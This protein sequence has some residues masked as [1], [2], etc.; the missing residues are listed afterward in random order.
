[1]H[2]AEIPLDLP[3]LIHQYGYWAVLLG[4]LLEGETVLLLAGYAAHRGYLDWTKVTAIAWI[5][6]T[7][8]DQCFFWLGRRHGA[9]LL[10]RGLIRGRL[11]RALALIEAHSLGVIFSMRFLYGLRIALPIA[12]GM[13]RV[14]AGRFASFNLV[15]AALWAVLVAGAGWVFG[16]AI[17]RVVGELHRYEAALMAGLAVAAWLLHRFLTRPRR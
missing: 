3:A 5:G 4:T 1:M 8:G 15:S 14:A 2:L 6:A 11:A 9:W 16:A 12:I 7:L 13:S 10:D 17:S